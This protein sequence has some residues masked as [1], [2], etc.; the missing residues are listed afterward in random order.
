LPGDLSAVC[1]VIERDSQNPDGHTSHVR[2][3]FDPEFYPF[4]PDEVVGGS[5]ATYEREFVHISDF[6]DQ[7]HP[8]CCACHICGP[9]EALEK[10]ELSDL[11]EKVALGEISSRTVLDEVGEEACGFV[12][13]SVNRVSLVLPEIHKLG[14]LSV[15]EVISFMDC[16]SLSARKFIEV[17]KRLKRYRCETLTLSDMAVLLE[18]YPSL[19]D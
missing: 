14:F 3:P 17:A 18:K 2:Y 15:C 10:A 8:D 9:R 4:D 19:A 1:D 13:N 12:E 6:A 5:P 16:F 7:G 11:V